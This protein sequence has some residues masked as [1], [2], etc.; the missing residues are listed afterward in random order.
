[1]GRRSPT[2]PPILR[3][4]LSSSAHEMAVIGNELEI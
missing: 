1:M 2:N 4:P 3:N